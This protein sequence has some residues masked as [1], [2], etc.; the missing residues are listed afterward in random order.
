MSPADL[1][2][3]LRAV[4]AERYHHL[5]PFHR[6]LHSGGCSK[7]EVQAWALNRYFYQS[8]IPVKDAAVIGQMTDGALRRAWI[9]RILDHDGH[10]TGEGMGAGGIA[11]WLALTDALG[12]DREMVVST[13][14]ILPGTRFAVEAYVTFCRTRP[15]LEAIASS[16]TEMF[17]PAIIGERVAGMLAHYDFIDEAALAYFAARPPQAARDADFAL[18][19]VLEHARTDE[20]Q[21]AVIAALRFKTDVL[22]QQLDALWLAYVEGMPPPGAWRP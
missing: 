9:S 4:G 13:C 17:S 16:L 18:A 5:H 1:E 11:R 19:Y 7:A 8:M 6:R 10:G 15:L 21:Q 3:A 2:A 20:A 14:G 22:W 12:L